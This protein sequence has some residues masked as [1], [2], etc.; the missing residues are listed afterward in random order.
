MAQV[1]V[2]WNPL[3]DFK[4]DISASDAKFAVR[5]YKPTALI[6]EYIKLIK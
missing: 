5:K 1:S 6:L 2:K 4:R 3:T